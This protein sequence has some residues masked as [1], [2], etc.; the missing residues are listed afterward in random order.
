MAALLSQETI[1]RNLIDTA[2]RM[3]ESVA[4]ELSRADGR[5]IR[6]EESPDLPLALLLP[7]DGFSCDVV[8]GIP[9]GLV[10]FLSPFQGAGMCRLASQPTSIGLWTVYM[11]QFNVCWNF[12]NELQMKYQ[13]NVI[14]D[15]NIHIFYISGTIPECYV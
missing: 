5:E 2:V 3:A 14:M 1:P 7:D 15:I 11:H 4:D 13:G 8:R 12:T 6:L 9:A 10:D